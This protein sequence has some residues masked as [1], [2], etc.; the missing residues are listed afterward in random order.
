MI[1]KTDKQKV[2][3]AVRPESFPVGTW[4]KLKESERVKVAAMKHGEW[5]QF[6]HD[7]AAGRKK[8]LK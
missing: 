6:L 1:K 3:P 8:I 4:G 2:L 7:R 5:I